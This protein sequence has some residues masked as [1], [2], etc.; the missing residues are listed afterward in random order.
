MY[1]VHITFSSQCQP[2]F[3]SI[4]RSLANIIFIVMVKVNIIIITV[5]V[6]VNIIGMIIIGHLKAEISF[7]I[8][9]TSS[10]VTPSFSAFRCSWIN[11]VVNVV[12][13]KV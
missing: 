12:K 10:S 3:I 6:M 11:K 13:V 5:M 4:V 2:F 9:L 1:N 8:S 7:L